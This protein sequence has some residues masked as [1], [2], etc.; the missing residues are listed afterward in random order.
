MSQIN[1]FNEV[2]RQTS[3]SRY[4]AERVQNFL[5]ALQG[6]LKAFTPILQ[7]AEPISSLVIGGATLVIQLGLKFVEFFEKLTDMMRVIGE[8]L[9]YLSKYATGF[10]GSPEVQQALARAYGDLLEFCQGAR[11]V[12]TDKQGNQ[13]HWTSFRVFFR[14]SWEPFEARFDRI[15]LQFRAHVDI[16]IRTANVVQYERVWSKEISEKI[17]EE[18]KERGDILRWLS[19]LDFEDDHETL[20]LKRYGVTG[21]WLIESQA[22]RDWIGADKSSILWCYGNPGA[23]KSVLASLVVD[24][25]SAQYA[26][27][28][29]SGLAFLYYKHQNREGQ[30][31]KDI[32]PALVKQLCRKKQ[33]LPIEV[34]ELY[35]QYSRQDQF[36]SLAKLQAQLTEISESFDQ[37]YIVIDALDECSDQNMVFAL[38]SALVRDSSV[39]IK[40]CV[41]SRREQYILH[42]FAKLQCPRLEIEAKKVDEDI[43]IFVDVEIDRRSED[44]QYGVIGLELK[45]EIKTSLITRSNGMFLWIEY[46]LINIFNQPCLDDIT[47]AINSLP[48]DMESTY[49]QILQTIEEK[50]PA[51]K[52]LAKRVL[53]WVVCAKRPLSLEELI[54]AVAIE[55]DLEMTADMKEYEGEAVIGACAN[56]IT[57]ENGVVTPVHY[58]VLEFLTAPGSFV[59]VASCTLVEKYQ[60]FPPDGHAEL[61]QLCMQYLRCGDLV[62]DYNRAP[63]ILNYLQPFVIYASLFWDYHIRAVD[64]WTASLSDSFNKFLSSPGSLGTAHKIRIGGFRL[65]PMNALNF[66]LSLGLLDLFY[67]FHRFDKSVCDLPQYRTALH[68]A[69]YAGS[70]SSIEGLLSMGFS[71]DSKDISGAAPLYH[72]C[73]QNR[74]PAAK[75][76][77]ERGADF[78]VNGGHYGN[79][80]QAAAVGGHQMVVV[81]LLGR[82][83]DVNNCGGSYGNP[84]QAAAHGGHKTVVGLLLHSGAKVNNQGGYY[85]NALQAAAHGGHKKVVGLLLQNGADINANGGSHGDALQAAAE[86]G[87]KWVVALLLGWGADINAQGGRY[88]NALQAALRNSHQPVVNLLRKHGAIEWHQLESNRTTTEQVYHLRA[89]RI[90]HHEQRTLTR[91]SRPT[92]WTTSD[93][94][95]DTL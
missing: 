77:L 88:G 80:L 7:Q 73:G 51:T 82:G 6:Y 93:D 46:Q 19:K 40:I 29:R 8:H 36:P 41:T 2:H 38:I 72:A 69:A 64:K 59:D 14:V 58:T 83:A 52:A 70:I 79:A 81:L 24:T 95:D 15:N 13:S 48:S 32:L 84:L 34:K 55:K 25:I 11:K 86:G 33:A 45:E 21:N 5:T 20:F 1:L 67:E 71:L 62:K 50:V 35:R 37:V 42:S 53:M 12:F 16:V 54:L 57:V 75:L 63:S 90:F 47:N 60:T 3:R 89:A 49:T 56:L 61:A 9:G 10:M 66:C 31:L 43:A 39:K 65:G 4:C 28:D 44:Y 91:R 85:G 92:C 68:H 27:D 23:G 87:H 78:N 18:D 22:F 74:V 76:F 30:K 94:K 26:L 17:Q